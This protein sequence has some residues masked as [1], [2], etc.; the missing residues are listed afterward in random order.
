MWS[1]SPATRIYLARG[2]T[3]LRK[4]YNGLYASVT[5]S[6][7]RDPLSGHLFVFCN[8]RRNRLKIFYW[9]GSG[10][11]V[12]GKRLERGRYTWP[13]T[14]SVNAEQLALLVGGM[15]LERVREKAWHRV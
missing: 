2:A 7:G 10:F 6:L 8:R 9:D 15:D 11:W 1:V 5:Q 13:A 12:C 4:S 3:D 14:E